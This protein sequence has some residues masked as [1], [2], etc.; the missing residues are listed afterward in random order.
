MLNR[1]RGD[2]QLALAAYNAGPAAVDR[3]GGIPPYQETQDY[4]Q[5]VMQLQ[6]Q[7]AGRG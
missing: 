6:Q 2:P 3:Y 5:K 4:V 1:Y 7:Y